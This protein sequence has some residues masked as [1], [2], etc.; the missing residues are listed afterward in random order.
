MNIGEGIGK[1]RVDEDGVSSDR[2]NRGGVGGRH[3]KMLESKFISGKSMRE[4]IQKDGVFYSQQGWPLNFLDPFQEPKSLLQQNIPSI[5]SRRS[6]VPW[7][8]CGV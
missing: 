4:R 6:S 7:Y 2:R 3:V 8:L 5:G 1:R